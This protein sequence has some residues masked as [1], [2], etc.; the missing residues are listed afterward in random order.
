MSEVNQNPVITALR[1]DPGSQNA[2]FARAVYTGAGARSNIE[3]LSGSLSGK[4]LG[5]LARF[6]S[7]RLSIPEF[8]AFKMI[9]IFAGTGQ[10]TSFTDLKNFFVELFKDGNKLNTKENDRLFEQLRQPE[11][12]KKS[13]QELQ[14]LFKPLI[15][16]L[17][18]LFINFREQNIRHKAEVFSKEPNQSTVRPPT[19]N[20]VSS[21]QA[22]ASWLVNNRAAFLM[23]KTNPEL[24]NLLL[25]LNNP[26]VAKSPVLLQEIY[27][28]ITQLIRL[29]RGRSQI[30]DFDDSVKDNL[31]SAANREVTEHEANIV[32]SLRQAVEQMPLK[33]FSNFLIE[34]ERFAEEEIA[35]MWSLAL[36]KEKELQKKL[37]D[38]VKKLQKKK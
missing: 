3:L 33:Q 28:M 19:S 23:L 4:D 27:K 1:P 15:K 29:K 26:N 17:K 16:D 34:A 7:S 14:P 31:N 37:G 32:H 20:L 21:P 22:F 38:G 12:Q 25:A 35:N 8:M 2:A 36:K 10:A 5:L 11:T 13:D 24:V 30:E 6:L 18:D 9:R